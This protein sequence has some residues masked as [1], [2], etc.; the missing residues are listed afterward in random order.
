MRV[1]METQPRGLALRERLL[2]GGRC[3]GQLPLKGLAQPSAC[4]P[5]I[6]ERGW[7]MSH[8]V[9]WGGPQS[10]CGCRDGCKGGKGAPGTGQHGV[11]GAG[12]R[13]AKSGAWTPLG[14]SRG[15]AVAGGKPGPAHPRHS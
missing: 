10:P 7:P 9:L 15:A 4:S 14:L 8:P 5:L 11:V 3:S 1:A 6:R 12:P 13:G 2:G